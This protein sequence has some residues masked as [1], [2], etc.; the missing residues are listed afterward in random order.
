MADEFKITK[1]DLS[2]ISEGTKV[3]GNILCRSYDIRKQ[4]NGQDYVAGTLHSQKD[5]P[6]KV[7]GSNEALVNI[8]KTKDLKGKV[9]NI[10]GNG[11]V[12]NNSV[13]IILNDI[14]IDGITNVPDDF[15]ASR[16][17]EEQYFEALRNLIEKTV[18]DKGYKLACEILFNNTGVAEKFKTNYAATSHHDNCKGGLLAHTYKM[19]RLMYFCLE[20]YPALVGIKSEN[21]EQKDY[22]DLFILGCLFHD[23]GKIDEIVAGAYVEKSIVKHTYLGLER[24]TAYK[25]KFISA[26][27]EM[28]WYNLCSILLQHHG[29]FG[30]PPKTLYAYLV[31]KVDMMDSEFTFLSTMLA[32][33]PELD[34][35][36]YENSSGALNILK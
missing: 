19:T 8:F 32:D 20:Q 29:E 31:H 23:L 14:G 5:I 26:Y 21:F 30:E 10:D 34:K 6:F 24:L 3:T 12:Y 36:F 15:L 1:D 17:D 16:Y 27:N 9:I 4:K 25:D 13:S 7:W 35:I 11:N 18:S 33:N 22:V 2:K 28:W